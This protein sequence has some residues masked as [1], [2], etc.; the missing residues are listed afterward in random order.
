MF[1]LI[2][3]IIYVKMAIFTYIPF[4]MFWHKGRLWF[5]FLTLDTCLISVISAVTKVPD[6]LSK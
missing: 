5:H 1:I 3:I 6:D 2:I 4:T